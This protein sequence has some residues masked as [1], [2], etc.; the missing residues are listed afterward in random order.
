MGP[1]IED[2]NGEPQPSSKE[3]R[4]DRKYWP[5]FENSL[6]AFFLTRPDGKILSANSAAQ[7]MFGMT[8]DELK[9]AGRDGIVVHD[10]R[11]EAAL[12]ERT[13]KGSARAELTYRRK[14]GSTFS[15][16]VTSNML[17]DLDGTAMISLIVRDIGERKVA[18]EALKESEAKYRSL[19]KE[20][21]S[22]ML[23]IDPS[24]GQIVD[25]NQAASDYYDYTYDELA[26][27]RI[28][29]I[30]ILSLDEVKAEMELSVSG[31]KRSFNFPHR[32]ASG[33]VRDV[34]VFSGPIV[35]GGRQL[36]YSIVHDVAWRKKAEEKVM[37]QKAITEG[38]NRIFREAIDIESDNDLSLVC[39][40]VAEKLTGSKFG[41][42]G[43]LNSRGDLEED[44]ISNLGWKECSI[45]APKGHGRLPMTLKPRGLFGRV[46]T[47][48]KAL[49]TNNPS[50]HPD[51]IGIPKGH[52]D[53][54]AFLGVPLKHGDKVI[55]IICVGNKDGG[56]DDE[57][58]KAATALTP[59]IVEALQRRKAEK[60]NSRSAAELKRSNEELQQF[61][62][63]AS[64]D[65]Q[66]PL[67][68]ITSYLRLLD[69]KFGSE[70]SP[71]AKEFV[72]FA[73]DGSLR[74]KELIDDLL[75]YSRIDSN[76]F[77]RSEIDMNRVAM[78]IED[79]LRVKIDETGAEVTVNILP[80]L[81]ADKT[82]MKQLLTNLISN[83]IKFRGSQIPRIEVSA[84]AY[85]NEYVFSVKDNGIG[86]DPRYQ[87]KL[88]KMFSRLHTRDEYPGTGIGLA[89]SKKIVD[90]HGG[91]IWFESEPGRGTTFFFTIPA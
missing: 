3:T 27:L 35:I 26:S 15:G 83:A 24:T 13:L 57:D 61:A 44:A 52:P 38:I 63:V 70:L 64:H 72:C 39:L 89:I 29:D 47:D 59:S 71:Q 54:T 65:L 34:E 85:E 79:D 87:D 20:N 53:L 19:F 76:I 80:A 22:V 77:E 32:L 91:R 73:M 88:F 41:F 51:G 2:K 1:N 68:T 9:A 37:R 30:N 28:T 58:L 86:I 6:D 4:C 18:E 48:G 74:M 69:K 42:I 14:D 50:G 7:K 90:R 55:G 46:V 49:Y 75:Q 5:L 82:Q 36:L 12:L 16:E 33:E 31:K 45:V 84:V 10:G 21:S 40:D 81:R 23:L 43:H 67:R 66:E 60:E 56:Y 78:T 8:E 11:P 25:A 17:T 62:Y